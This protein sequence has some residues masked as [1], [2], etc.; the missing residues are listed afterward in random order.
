MV[1]RWSIVLLIL[2]VVAGYLIAGSAV[3]ADDESLPF[4]TGD[5]VTLLYAIQNTGNNSVDCSVMG[6][7][8]IYIRCAP[9]AQGPK[10]AEHWHSL[11][12]IVIVRATT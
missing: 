2:G 9:P 4:A 11:Q 3:R 6:V 8:G 7:R 12:S 5:R 1:T 10:N